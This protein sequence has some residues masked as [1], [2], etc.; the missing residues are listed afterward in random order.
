MLTV[1]MM[2]LYKWEQQSGEPYSVSRICQN[3]CETIR[4]IRI[5][6]NRTKLFV[7]TEM[8]WQRHDD[9]AERTLNGAIVGGSMVGVANRTNPHSAPPTGTYAD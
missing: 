5:E 7:E 2:P 3:K 9:L 6:E 8:L 1:I 4:V